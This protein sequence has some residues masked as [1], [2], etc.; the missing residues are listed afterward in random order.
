M[1]VSS[2]TLAPAD[3]AR[4]AR[5]RVGG[6][7]AQLAALVEAGERVPPFVVVTADALARVVEQ[8]TVHEA[9]DALAAAHDDGLGAAAEAAQRALRAAPWP[10][11]VATALVGAWREISA[12]GAHTVAVRSSAAEEDGEGASFAGLFRSLTCVADEQMF[13]DAVRECWA[14]AASAGAVAYRRRRALGAGAPALALVVQRMV[15]GEVSGVLFTADPSSGARHRMRVDATWGLCEGVVNADVPA[16]SWSVPWRGTDMTADVAHKDRCVSASPA[17]AVELVTVPDDRQDVPCLD[18]GRLD[19]LRDLGARA[20]DLLGGPA[21]VEWTFGDGGLW[22]LQARPITALPPA[23]PEGAPDYLFDNS[24]IVESYAGVTLPLTFSYIRY[25]Y[26]IAYRQSCELSGVPADEIKA[27]ARTFDSMLALLDGRVYYNLGSWYRLLSLFPGFE[28][29]A[30]HMERMMGVREAARITAQAPRR[31][32]RTRARMGW[33]MLRN[34]FTAARLVRRFEREFAAN[35]EDARAQ[36][37]KTLTLPELLDTFHVFVQRFLW[38]WQAPL[39]TDFLAMVFHGTL[40]DLVKRWGLDDEGALHNDLLTGAGGIESAEPTKALLAL[41][42][43]LRDDEPLREL[44]AGLDDERCLDVLREDGRFDDFVAG[45]DDYLERWGARAMNELKL[46]EPALDERPGFVFA[47]LKNYL[48][49]A[50]DDG[51]V[52]ARERARRAAAERRVRERLRNPIKRALLSFVLRR[53]RRH[54]R[55]RESMRLSRTRVFALLR[56][57]FLELGRRFEERGLIDRTD[58]VFYL[59][60]D[61]VLGVIDATSTTADLRGLVRV[62]SAE[63]ER[64]HR[65]PD[66]DDRVAVHGA[67]RLDAALRAEVAPAQDGELRGLPCS[68]GVVRGNARVIRAGDGD[69]RL[70]DDILVAARTDPGWVPLYPSAR[71]LLVERGSLLSH[72]AIVARE[73]GLP[74]I[75]NI[76]RLL[77]HVEDGASIEMDGDRGT[78]R[79]TEEAS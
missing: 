79:R 57:F 41:A 50:V 36:D 22:A 31:T 75:V 58:D 68:P 52:E 30:E 3:A 24:N 32:R 51:D 9:L 71:G 49:G 27:H 69:V 11:E 65:L 64:H 29:N 16:D 54:V 55:N 23:P 35:Y 53:A 19:E 77:Q 2:Y 14:S 17:G 44:V 42:R 63:Y 70:D 39:I 4:A 8:P 60:L 56:R 25:A 18:E 45:L 13:V 47:V 40:R 28:K 66:P 15:V 74:T 21:D 26:G 62:R 37:L 38:R 12:D 61:E 78:V 46:E 6:K 43:Q 59:E 67:A 48:R 7:A 76:P 34:Y 20:H 72:A 73:L 10:D 5:A 1:S 33:A